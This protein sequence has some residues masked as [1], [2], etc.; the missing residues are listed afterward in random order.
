MTSGQRT[1]FEEAR[2]DIK[3]ERKARRITAREARLALSQLAIMEAAL[4][5]ATR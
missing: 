3:A 4:A 2:H 1:I 5:V